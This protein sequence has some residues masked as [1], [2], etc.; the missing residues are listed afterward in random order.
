[1]VALI[2]IENLFAVLSGMQGINCFH[3]GISATED[4]FEFVESQAADM[5]VIVFV[6]C[7]GK[8]MN[9]VNKGVS[10]IKLFQYLKGFSVS[11]HLDAAHLHDIDFRYDFPQKNPSDSGFIALAVRPQGDFGMK[12]DGI[13][14]ISRS[15]F[16]D[17]R[18]NPSVT[19]T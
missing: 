19:L 1:M 16:L 9:E 8:F 17:I 5:P 10:R 12:I 6:V 11:C 2:G 15:N 13:A 4:S 14:I 18:K 7:L 3:I